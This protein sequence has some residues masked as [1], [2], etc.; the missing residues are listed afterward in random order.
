MSK[1]NRNFIQVSGGDVSIIP[2]GGLEQIGLNMT[3]F[4]YGNSII[5]VDCGLAFPGEDMP[6]VDLVVPD[7]TYLEQNFEK[8]RGIFITHGHEDHIGAL[9]YV[10]LKLNVPL[11]ATR[12]T[13]AIIEDKLEEH[14]MNGMVKKNV[15]N[16]GDVVQAG[17]FRV[18]FIRTNHSIADRKSVV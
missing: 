3:A 17:D 13:M 2:L 12:L 15:V 16:Y 18:E 4:A 11:Y 5:V 8:I 7:V 10:L 14:E 6:G 1:K 9:P